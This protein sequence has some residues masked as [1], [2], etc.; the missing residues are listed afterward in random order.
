M[1]EYSILRPLT[2]DERKEIAPLNSTSLLDSFLAELAKKVSF[3]Q[4]QYRPYD[5]YGARMDF[6]RNVANKMHEMVNAIDKKTIKRLDFGN[7]DEYSDLKRFNFLHKKE[8]MQIRLLAGI[9]QEVVTGYRYTF[10]TKTRGNKL[11][12]LVPNEGVEE[13]DKWVDTNFGE[14]KKEVKA[15]EVKV[16]E[17]KAPKEVKK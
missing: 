4:K 14:K 7:L 15:K 16:T 13:F 2:V 8:Q 3:Y 11:S 10:K 6:E 12:L 9:K 5:S 1:G 17:T